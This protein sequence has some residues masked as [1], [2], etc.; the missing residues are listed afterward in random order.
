MVEKEE[1]IKAQQDLQQQW[2]ERYRQLEEKH[3]EQHETMIKVGRNH[4]SSSN[5]IS[6]SLSSQLS[7]HLAAR[8]SEAL[9]ATTDPNTVNESWNAILAMNK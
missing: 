6:S 9:A 5:L 3:K 1:F 4:R 2:E 8:E 7:T